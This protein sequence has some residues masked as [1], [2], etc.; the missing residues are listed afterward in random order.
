MN[1]SSNKGSYKAF[2]VDEA[3][4]VSVLSG[5]IAKLPL[6]RSAE[7]G[8]L[9]VSGFTSWAMRRPLALT[10]NT[11]RSRRMGVIALTV[12]SAVQSHQRTSRQER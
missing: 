9:A 11:M 2:Y 4:I 6:L 10:P 12:E 5:K 3:L 1:V 7:R 8:L